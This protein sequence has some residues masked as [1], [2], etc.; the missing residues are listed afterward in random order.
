MSE[1][2]SHGQGTRDTAVVLPFAVA[3]LVMPPVV[4]VFAA[5]ALFAGIPL[6]VVYLYG[7]WAFAVLAA[8]LVAR[9]LE[10]LERGRTKEKIEPG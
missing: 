9:R 8:L 4:L 3:A 1:W 7:V 10:R 5:P 2:D 6:I